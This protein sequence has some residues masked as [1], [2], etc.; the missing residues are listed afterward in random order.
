M[1]LKTKSLLIAFLSLSACG[2][3]ST[4][5][6]CVVYDSPIELPRAAAEIVVDEA[7]GEA[8]KIAARNAYRAEHCA[9]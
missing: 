8:E 7:R 5:T 1:S 2:S 6:F 4:D 9:P 3:I